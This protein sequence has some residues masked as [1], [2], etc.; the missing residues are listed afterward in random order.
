MTIFGGRCWAVSVDFVSSLIHLS[1]SIIGRDSGQDETRIALPH[2]FYDLYRMIDR[3]EAG[4]GL[5]S[6][7]MGMDVFDGAGRFGKRGFDYQHHH[8]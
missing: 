5:V 1:T 6:M 4:V 2:N 3:L 8:H 7:G